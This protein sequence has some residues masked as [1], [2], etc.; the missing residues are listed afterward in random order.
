MLPA[1]L[2]H[3]NPSVVII[4]GITSATG[5]LGSLGAF[6]SSA[7]VFPIKN[8][9]LPAFGPC[10]S[11]T[12]CALSHEQETQSVCLW[13][14]TVKKSRNLATNTAFPV[15]TDKSFMTRRNG[16]K[17]TNKQRTDIGNFRIAAGAY[18]P[19]ISTNQRRA[20]MSVSCGSRRL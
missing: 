2:S 17:Q 6:L 10:L 5:P 19:S 7:L 20:E 9:S 15:Y 3:H 18:R 12:Q 14:D 1:L 16:S 11:A 4:R 13:S 8:Q